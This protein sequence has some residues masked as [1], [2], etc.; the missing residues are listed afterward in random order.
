MTVRVLKKYACDAGL[1]AAERGILRP[2]LERRR[3]GG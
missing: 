2:F 3:V 1:D